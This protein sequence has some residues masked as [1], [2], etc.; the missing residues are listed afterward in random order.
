MQKQIEYENHAHIARHTCHVRIDAVVGC[1][2]IRRQHGHRRLDHLAKPR[3]RC[4][5]KAQEAADAKAK[6]EAERKAKQE[7]EQR[8][9]QQAREQQA[10]EQ[11]GKTVALTVLEELPV[12]GRAPK[13]GYSRDQFGPV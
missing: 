9:A 2:F 11:A 8:E 10:N 6:E 7:A 5:H 4:R 3:C 13:T 1:L 12:K